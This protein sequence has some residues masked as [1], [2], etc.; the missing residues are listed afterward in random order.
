MRGDRGDALQAGGDHPARTDTQRE[1]DRF[2]QGG[3]PRRRITGS[4]QD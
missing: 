1:L 4:G 2:T 3:Q